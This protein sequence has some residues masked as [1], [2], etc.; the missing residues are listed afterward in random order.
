MDN[1]SAV[2]GRPGVNEGV[3]TDYESAALTAE[4][5]AQI[6]YLRGLT[7]IIPNVIFEDYVPILPRA[8]LE[9]RFDR[10]SEGFTERCE[11]VMPL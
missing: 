11:I 1:N 6:I 10:L 7:A 4:L 5:R 8:F 2:S 9:G 3:K